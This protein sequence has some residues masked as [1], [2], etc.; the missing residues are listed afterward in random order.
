[1]SSRIYF[2]F[3]LLM[4]CGVSGLAQDG[5]TD[6]LERIAYTSVADD[7][8]RDFFLYLP[9]GYG[10]DKNK[11]W[12][13]LLF[14]HG[15]GERGDGKGQLGHALTHGPLYEAWI[16]KRDLPFIMIVPQLQMFDRAAYS[17]YLASRSD[18][19]IL[20]RQDQG[21][22]ARNAK[23]DT[24]IEMNGVPSTDDYPYENYGPPNGWERV[25]QDLIY[26]LDYVKENYQSDQSRVYLSGLSYGGFGT[27][28]MASKY[29]ERFA[30]INP[31]VGWGHKDLMKPIAAAQL[32]V[33]CIAG[34]R[35]TTIQ[36]QF[37]Y[38]GLNELEK[39]GHK[40][41]RFSIEVDMNHDVWSR[42]Y[43]GQDIYDWLL[44]HQQ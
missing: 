41:V 9:R 33:W 44:S 16:Q 19:I 3:S 28:Y 6:R 31:V 10:E 17:P 32:P 43:A 7:Q 20:E 23:F 39:L 29:P 40:N 14:L 12:P 22:P 18:D 2:L 8:E 15:N 25:E 37:F 36:P 35:D 4:Y 5:L 24:T 27:W 26:L 11:D 42:V 21:V 13:V 38:P 30:A 34:G 1:M